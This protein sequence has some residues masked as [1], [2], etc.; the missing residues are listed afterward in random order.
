MNLVDAIVLAALVV[1]AWT[2]WRQGFVAGL[3]SFGGFLV[4]ALAAA[5]LLPRV[6]EGRDLPGALGP[7]LL[8]TA[9]LLAALVGLL[10]VL[11]PERAPVDFERQLQARAADRV[12]V[13][14]HRVLGAVARPKQ[15]HPAGRHLFGILRF[16]KMRYR[17]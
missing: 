11:E 14:P 5:L 4:G 6:F 17:N 15:L 3:L 8:A 9:I 12:A 10:D 7:L 2:G 13:H 1:F 16:Q